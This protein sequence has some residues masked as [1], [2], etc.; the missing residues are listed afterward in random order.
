MFHDSAVEAAR[1]G[2]SS[3]VSHRRG[4]WFLPRSVMG[5]PFGMRVLSFLVC[6][7]PCMRLHA[8]VRAASQWM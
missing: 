2:A 7:D 6:F 4:Y 8:R 5:I 3:H 1:F